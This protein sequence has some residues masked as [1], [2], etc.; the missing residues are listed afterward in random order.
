LKNVASSILNNGWVRRALGYSDMLIA[1][2][3]V[4]VVL[5][6]IVPVPPFL[7]DILFAL[8][9]SLSLIVFL[10]TMF[11]TET[12]QFSVFPALLLVATLF[13]LSLNISST[14]LILQDASAG[15]IIAAFGNFVVGGN[16]VVGLVIFI[17]I[18]VIQFVV[19]T[20]GAGR[21]AEVSA[22]FTLDAMPGKQMSID[23]DFNSGLI[24][25]HTARERRQALQREADFYGAMD[26]ASKFV[27][28]DAIVSIVI[29][30]VNILGGLAIGIVQK[31]LPVE[32]AVHIYT[33]L[34]IGDGLVSQIPALLISTAAGLLVTRSANSRSFGDDLSR[35]LLGFP[36]VIAMA[37][38]IVLFLGLIPG[39]PFIP[40]FVLALGSGAT[41]YLLHGEEKQRKAHQKGLEEREA[42]QV[43]SHP[44][45]FLSLIPVD[46]LEVELG[47]GLLPLT[48]K[49]EGGDLLERVTAARRVCALEM[50]LVVQPIR[51]RDNLQLPADSYCIRLKGNIIGS[52]TLK[53]GYCLAMDPGG[54]EEQIDGIPTREPAFGL[55]AFWISADK[56]EEAELAGY[57]VVDESTVLVT[58]LTETLKKHGHELLGRQETKAL[59]DMV[60]TSRPAVV[61]ELI[62][63]LLGLGDIQKVL[64][65]LLLERVP[66]R[67]MASI[68]E[69]LADHAGASKDADYLT[70]MVRQALART[71]CSFYLDHGGRL[72][73]LTL[74]PVLE[75]EIYESLQPSPQ[76]IYPVLS[77]D[78]TRQLFKSL[79]ARS[80]EMT[81]RGDA[82][83]PGVLPDSPALTPPAGTPAFP[84][85]RTFLQRNC[86]GH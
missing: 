1:L 35:Q 82:G 45:S 72:N 46:A 39:L 24:D 86:A 61:E 68:L 73:V 80:E 5:I 78:K 51:V 6:I 74:A 32:E 83:S 77:P 48:E 85:G 53:S 15:Q 66:I 33:L 11:T 17:I 54:A 84:G 56:K 13:R 70:E 22:R 41:A 44:D 2:S 30:L 8:S 75:Q 69:A 59:V 37:A 58:H 9:I 64:Q 65:N 20:S 55:P 52:G 43:S 25:E 57:T 10:L 71:I 31:G 19:I 12:L 63:G 81:V 60:K 38:G 28:G 67:D 3:I 62:P 34:T 7:L 49:R 26:G 50:G 14:R 23:A 29:V 18:T 40:F 16:Y 42:A 79:S 4:A 21:V 47:Y 36:R 76:G 27:K